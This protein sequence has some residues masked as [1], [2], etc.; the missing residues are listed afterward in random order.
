MK[1]ELVSFK[2]DL[3]YHKLVDKLVSITQLGLGSKEY[4]SRTAFILDAIHFHA[5][6]T[7]KEIYASVPPDA[8]A[9]LAKIL[10]EHQPVIDDLN[11]HAEE[12]VSRFFAENPKL[13]E[14]L[15]GQAD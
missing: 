6:F 13:I 14:E 2:M 11:G 5:F 8:T 12:N 1:R 10:K 7:L 9:F 4:D 15:R 3:E